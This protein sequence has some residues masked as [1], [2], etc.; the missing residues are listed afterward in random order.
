MKKCKG[1]AAQLK[2]YFNSYTMNKL[3]D[4]TKGNTINY[5]DK[6]MTDKMSKDAVSLMRMNTNKI[7]NCNF[8]IIL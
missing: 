2:D 8:Y 4:S 3:Q 7:F 5:E 6:K 1:S